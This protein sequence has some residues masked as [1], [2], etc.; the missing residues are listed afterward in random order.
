MEYGV[1]YWALQQ[2]KRKF[3]LNCT[4]FVSN[5]ELIDNLFFSF[6]PQGL[7]IHSSMMYVAL[8]DLMWT[9]FVFGSFIGRSFIGSF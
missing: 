9:L 5:D 1:W 2:V 4:Q 3:A 7:F 6:L 8:K